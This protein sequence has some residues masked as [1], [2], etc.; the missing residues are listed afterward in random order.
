VA[1]ERSELGSARCTI[2]EP[3]RSRIEQ[4]AHRANA[5]RIVRMIEQ[6]IEPRTLDMT[7]EHQL[8]GSVFRL[9]PGRD[10]MEGAIAEAFPSSGQPQLGRI[11]LQVGETYD[12]VIA[13]FEI[14]CERRQS[15][16]ELA[17][18]T[19][20]E[21]SY[22]G[23]G[24]TYDVASVAAGTGHDLQIGNNI[25][26]ADARNEVALHRAG[27][28]D[29]KPAAHEVDQ[30]RDLSV[31]LRAA[32]AKAVPADQLRRNREPAFDLRMC[33]HCAG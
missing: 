23:L 6:N 21:A 17:E 16:R 14:G 15:S 32:E 5:Q 24:R 12:A 4:E 28:L 27:E 1:R 22:P 29:D 33:K 9:M 11:E 8:H 10:D 3:G 31:P 30:K 18:E 13:A 25:D 19:V 7:V 2:I 20:V 26:D